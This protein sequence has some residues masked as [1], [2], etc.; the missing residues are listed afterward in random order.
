MLERRKHHPSKKEAKGRIP[1]RL[2]L[3]LQCG[4]HNVQ[5]L[6]WPKWPYQKIK[7]ERN[8]AS[9]SSLMCDTHSL[10]R[11]IVVFSLFFQTCR[12]EKNKIIFI[13]LSFRLSSIPL[14]F[15]HRS[16]TTTT[17]SCCKEL[18]TLWHRRYCN[19][20]LGNLCYSVDNSGNN[21]QAA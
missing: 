1:L 8:P 14:I 3:P 7:R 5:N 6:N 4:F 9:L 13:Y 18:W 2:P 17:I 20:H 12:K 19:H 10:S 15:S 16:T 21:P 11:P